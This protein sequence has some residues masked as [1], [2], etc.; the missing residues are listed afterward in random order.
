MEFEG[1]ITMM[2]TEETVWQN[3][4]RKITLVIE[5][6]SDRDYKQSLVLEQLWDKKVDLAKWFAQWDKVRATLDCRAREYNGRRYNS[7]SAW[8]IEKSWGT[9]S[10]NSSS[11]DLPF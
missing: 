2:W 4:T 11:D 3:S 5:E 8:R 9:S 7:L 6:D 1:I 10:S